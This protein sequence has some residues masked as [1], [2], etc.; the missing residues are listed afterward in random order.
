MNIQCEGMDIS[1]VHR[2]SAVDEKR[3]RLSP[4]LLSDDMNIGTRRLY[5]LTF[6]VGE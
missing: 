1:G 2:L 5:I 4:R 6:S 3:I